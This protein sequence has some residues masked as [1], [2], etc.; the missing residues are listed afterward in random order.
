MNERHRSS[1]T[2]KVLA[3]SVLI[4]LG[5]LFILDNFGVINAGDVSDYWPL[6]LIV[7]GVARL[8]R[9]R[10]PGERLWG[11]IFIVI[12]AVFLLR[13][14]NI[15]WISFHQVWP[16][17]LVVIGIYLV[18]QTTARQRF[19]DGAS[20]RGNLGER[21]HEGVAAGREA[22]RDFRPPGAASATLDE[23]ALFGGGDRVVRSSDFRGGSV[24]AIFGG[25]DI[26]LR[27]ATIVGEAAV[28][29]VFVMFGGVDIRVPEEWSVIVNATPIL[30]NSEYKP[31]PGRA[32]EGPVKTLTI[33][34]MVIFGGVEIKN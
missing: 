16:V 4:L 20:A 6:F 19:A 29:D 32:V 14:L 13:N 5:V 1:L 27:E 9:P 8:T 23:F 33:T 21:I 17:A 10:R 11:G 30:G 34:G 3:G 2:P 25:F 24:T 12:G 26:D 31:R 28:I 22:S 7:L 18:W 15:V